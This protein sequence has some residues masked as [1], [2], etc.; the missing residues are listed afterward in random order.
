MTVEHAADG[1]LDAAMRAAVMRHARRAVSA[2]PSNQVLAQYGKANR[3]PGFQFF[4]LQDRI[5]V[6]PESLGKT[7]RQIRRDIRGAR[8]IVQIGS[9]LRS[10][11][12]D[13]CCL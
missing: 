3:L 12:W 4:G 8:Q 13:R 2:A 5:P 9:A 11:Y 1:K 6:V 10:A 7:G